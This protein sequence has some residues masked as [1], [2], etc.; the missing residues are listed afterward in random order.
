[1][2]NVWAYA[3]RHHDRAIGTLKQF[4]S[5]LP[6]DQFVSYAISVTGNGENLVSVIYN[7]NKKGSLN[8]DD[9]KAKVRGGRSSKSGPGRLRG[10]ANA[11]A[12][13]PEVDEL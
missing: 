11:A 3:D 6:P 9:D 4:L 2:L 5:A 7:P 10:A 8:N 1:M 13:L 12:D